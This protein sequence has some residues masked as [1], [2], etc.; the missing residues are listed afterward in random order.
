MPT[1]LLRALEQAQANP[2]N[3]AG[4]KPSA[5]IIAGMGGSAISGDVVRCLTADQL[6]VPLQVS[7]SYE[8][9][10]WINSQTLAIISSY[11]GDTEETLSAMKQAHAAGAQIVCVTSGGAI[12]ELAARWHYPVFSLPPGF[13]PRS[14]L[15]FLVVPLLQI[16]HR[17]A[18]WEN[19]EPAIR[20]A[21]H[22]LKENLALWG[23]SDNDQKNVPMRIAKALV[24]RTPIIYGATLLTEVAAMR[25]KGQFCE[26]A[27]ILAWHNAFPEMNHNEIVGWRLRQE[28]NSRLQ[29]IFLRDREDHPRVQRRLD[30]TRELIEESGHQVIEGW[31]EGVSR[32]ARLFSLVLM[33]DLASLYL[34][35][36][37]EVDPT[38]V[39]S[40]TRLKQQLES[41]K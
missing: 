32:F 17:L 2:Y 30:F 39:A 1:H 25:W 31:S 22:L 10:A 9:P 3:G 24:E 12:G 23:V 14:A 37:T 35:I 21:A 16:L 4:K 8:L 41:V 36:M 13:P 27:E 29:P 20:E 40:I 7:R 5:I 34:A 11:S 18:L 38:P 6:A 19:P 15:A 26:N 33:G 28:F